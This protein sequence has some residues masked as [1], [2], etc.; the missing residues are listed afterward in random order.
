MKDWIRPEAKLP[1]EGKPVW[2]MDRGGHVQQLIY[3]N[4]LWWFP[5]RSMYV[6]YV[7]LFWVEDE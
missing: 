5:D 2:A 3:E 7:P 6:Y 4:G 1:P